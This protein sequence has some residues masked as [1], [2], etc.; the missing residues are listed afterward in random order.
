M[1]DAI[2]E[3]EA[4]APML[5][6]VVWVAVAV[7]ATTFLGVALA[8]DLTGQLL[9]SPGDL[10][11]P[12]FWTACA[13]AHCL[14]RARASAYCSFLDFFEDLALLFSREVGVKVSSSS[15]ALRFLLL[16]T[17]GGIFL[18]LARSC[19]RTLRDGEGYEFINWWKVE[20]R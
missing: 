2:V 6:A 4:T 12:F 7:T 15:G 8:D 16:T 11:V 9:L 10:T 18:L 1:G 14:A 5:D 19:D 3:A 20:E 17:R 13:S